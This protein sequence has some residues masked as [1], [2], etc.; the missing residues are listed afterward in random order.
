M[1]KYEKTYL[2]EEGMYRIRALVGIPRHG[3]KAGDLGGMI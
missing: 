3:V 1:K 2:P